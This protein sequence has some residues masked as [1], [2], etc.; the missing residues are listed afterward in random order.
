MK[1]LTSQLQ[2]INSHLYQL[3][4]IDD[5]LISAIENGLPLS[6]RPYAE[7]ARQLG[8]EEQEVTSRLATLKIGRASCRERV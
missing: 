2:G 5:A 1:T 8:I 4:E 7:I 3:D 6:S